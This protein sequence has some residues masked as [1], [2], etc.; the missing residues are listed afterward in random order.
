LADTITIVGDDIRS[1]ECSCFGG[2]KDYHAA[3]SS[4]LDLPPRA[5]GR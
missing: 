5:G 1:R 3:L 2:G 4:R